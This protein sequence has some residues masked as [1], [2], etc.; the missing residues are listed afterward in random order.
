[1]RSTQSLSR[2]LVSLIVL[3][4]LC[5]L[6]PSL[7]AN[8]AERSS[9]H[10]KRHEVAEMSRF[11]SAAKGGTVRLGRASIYVP[12]NVMLKRSKVSVTKLSHGRYDMH[13]AG[14]WSGSVGVTLPRHSKNA[15]LM[16]RIRGTW[17]PE[18]RPGQR[19]VVVT[20][21]SVF[22]WITD[23]AKAA[24]CFVS[25]SKYK[26]LQCLAGK[27]GKTISGQVAD[28]IAQKLGTNCYATLVLE[29]VLGGPSSVAIGAF[30]DPACVGNAGETYHVPVVPPKPAPPKAAPPA[31]K[32]V[33]PGTPA[34]TVVPGA[35]Q[36]T[37]GGRA[38]TW[39]DPASA[40][41]TNGA[42]IPAGATVSVSCRVTGFKVAN[43]NTW[44]YRIASSPWNNAFY[45]TADAFYNNGSRSGSLQGTPFVDTSVP[46]CAGSA[47]PPP[48]TRPETVGGNANTWTNYTNAGGT[49]GPTIPNGTTVAISCKVTGFKVADGNT[50]W[51]R[52]ASSPWNNAYYVSA[53]AFYNNGATSGSLHGTPFVDPA[54][55][56]C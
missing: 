6:A 45:A 18:G 48:E 9:S 15:V 51:Y 47:P 56:N 24:V 44:W 27:L 36:E 40:G 13:I 8:A 54:V 39:T 17:L 23:K 41:G 5:V 53:D 22:S 21:L 32:P 33:P 34:P 26:F 42:S 38:N 49:Q 50:W 19:K 31:P 11:L 10:G 37:A 7:S 16:H 1:M 28:W 29:G 43:G 14:P 35:H 12:P 4:G 2:M 55:P 20:H 52:I 46:L 30:T 25:F 3:V